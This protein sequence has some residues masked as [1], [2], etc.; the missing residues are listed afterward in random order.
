M[1]TIDSAKF[2]AAFYG[3]ELSSKAEAITKALDNME[4]KY[5]ERYCPC[6]VPRTEDTICPCKEFRDGGKCICGLFT[7]QEL[8]IVQLVDITAEPIE[9]MAKIAGTCYQKE[10][11]E[12]VV[13]K[14]IESGHLGLLE[15]CYATFRL[16]I[17]TTVLA[18]ITRHRHFS[19]MVQSSRGCEISRYTVPDGAKFEEKFEESIQKAMAEYREALARGESFETAAYL[20]PKGA[21]VE[22][23]V[24]G[25]FRVWYE[26]LPKRLCHRANPEHRKVAMKIA[27]LFDYFCPLVN[28]GMDC[29]NCPEQF[30]CDF[31]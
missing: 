22:V 15:H 31:R 24:T 17:S 20:L 29:L 21:V 25:N 26:Y 2:T 12:E 11:N 28:H 16:V 8:P 23:Y 27:D 3:V 5:G 19:F 9:K 14:I 4:E 1:V 18:Q 30:G 6:R 10:L 7:P 13:K